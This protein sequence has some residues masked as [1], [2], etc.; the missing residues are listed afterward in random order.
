MPIRSFASPSRDEKTLSEEAPEL[1]A[2]LKAEKNDPSILSRMGLCAGLLACI[3]AVFLFWPKGRPLLDTSMVFDLPTLTPETVSRQHTELLAKCKI[4]MG[5]SQYRAC[6]DLLEPV[7]KI[8]L[9]DSGSFAE[10]SRL[11][12]TYLNCW[13]LY[14]PVD[15]DTDTME[16]VDLCEKALQYQTSPEWQ[17]FKLYFSWVSYKPF[18]L[19]FAGMEK[20]LGKSLGPK[21]K[22]GKVRD[23]L[24]EQFKDFS[25]TADNI[26]EYL[27][28]NPCDED[29]KF[30][31]LLDLLHCQIL[32]A[33]WIVEGYK[34]YPDDHLEDPGVPQ[35]ERAY[36]IAEKYED[37]IAFLTIR[38]EIVKR[39]L[40]A[41]GGY[42]YFKGKR[43]WQT[44]HLKDDLKA[45]DDRIAATAKS[46]A[47]NQYSP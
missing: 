44:S 37:D 26:R 23:Q 8:I 33:Q 18:Y 14:L 25:K 43:L 7:V 2:A 30:K 46:K 41:A 15:S 16:L 45:I 38:K 29:N 5:N 13:R 22:R 10:N 34:K 39:I 6:I 27:A 19:D 20:V 47:E 4:M 3:I 35:R 17:L 24:I 9:E 42:Y 12:S 32:V 36:E 28:N 1:L 11:L 21:P 40:D 31:S